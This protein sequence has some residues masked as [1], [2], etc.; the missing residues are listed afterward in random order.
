VATR[1]R[2]LSSAAAAYVD[3]EVAEAADG[4]IAWSRFEAL[5]D[6]T[7]AAAA[8]LVAREK[9]E[10]ASQASFAKRLRGEA[11][12]M[13]SFL[14]RADVATIEQ[15]DAAVTATA[16]RL[17]RTMPEADADERR[18]R[19]TLLMANP[20]ADE[21]TPLPDLLPKVQ[22]FVHV[23]DGPRTFTA[24]GEEVGTIARVEG[25]GPVTEAWLTRVLGPRARITVRPVID[26]ALQAPVDAYEI[27][28]RHRQAVHLM[29]PA[30]TFPFATC[31]SR[32]MQIDHTVPYDQG[33]E[34]AVGNYGPMTATHH[35]V[36]T[37]SQWQVEQPFPG[38][39][40]W[41]DPHGGLYLVDHTGTRR[42]RR[43][44]RSEA[45]PAEL[46]FRRLSVQLALAA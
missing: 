3:S 42:V 28:G 2:E 7:I 20:G 15:I 22:L 27:P 14:I 1:C 33:G 32:Q 4:R 26:L 16:E 39:Y 10:R 18:V 9:E 23:H 41:R 8:P 5:V 11:H 31:T 46:T 40:V 12:G 24:D 21:T 37:H 17:T 38:I 45:S 35:R 43:A 30:D 36:K 13:A 25:H 34:S 6:A 29:T 19:A 44:A